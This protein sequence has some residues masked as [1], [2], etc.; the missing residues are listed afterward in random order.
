MRLFYFLVFVTFAFSCSSNVRT[1]YSDV[2]FQPLD[3]VLLNERLSQYALAH[4]TDMPGLMIEVAKSFLN[5]PYAAKTLE[6]GNEE[7][8]VVNLREFD[9]TTLIETVMAISHTLHGNTPSFDNYLRNLMHIRYRQG[10]NSG[11]TSRLHYFTDWITDNISKGYLKDVSPDY[12]GIEYPNTLNFMSTHTYAYEQLKTDSALVDEM[13]AIEAAISGRTYHYI[14]KEKIAGIENGL[15]H[16]LIVAFTTNIDGLDVVHAGF[17]VRTNGETRLLHASSDEGAVVLSKK[18]L[19]GYTQANR[20]Q[21]GIILL[22]P[23]VK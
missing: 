8:P 16:G 2:H 22:Q 13:K 20:L 14:P 7:K 6:Q 23:V 19:S 18:T 17:I 12:G 21:T 1:A 9:C 4:D 3:T 11:Y 5:F 15:E 10:V